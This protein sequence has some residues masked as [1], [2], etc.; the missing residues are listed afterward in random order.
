MFS[1]M[2]EAHCDHTEFL[3]NYMSVDDIALI[4]GT[5]GRI[6]ARFHS[7]QKCE[8]TE[9]KCVFVF[10]I[11]TFYLPDLYGGIFV[12]FFQRWEEPVTAATFTADILNSLAAWSLLTLAWVQTTAWRNSVIQRNCCFENLLTL[13]CSVFSEWRTFEF[14]F[15]HMD[16]IM[17]VFHASVLFQMTQKL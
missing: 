8:G 12:S 17:L 7:N 3:S 2:E 9:K 4:P 10:S 1:G 15:F 5:L 6:R 11:F 13:C 14:E 16:L